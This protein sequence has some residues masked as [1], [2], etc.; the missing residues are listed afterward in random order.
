MFFLT[1]APPKFTKQPQTSHAY[2]DS[3]ARFECAAD[4]FPKPVITWRKNGEIQRGSFFLEIGDGYLIVKA[5]VQLD[6]GVYQCFAS[7]G[8]GNIQAAAELLVYRKGE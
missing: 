4:G 7:N 2:V 1:P 6:M 8:L 3:D 5:L